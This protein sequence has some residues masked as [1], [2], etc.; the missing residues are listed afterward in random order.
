MHTLSCPDPVAAMN[1][2]QI[3]L[4]LKHLDTYVPSTSR[5][6]CLGVRVLG[7]ACIRVPTAVGTQTERCE[8]CIERIH[9]P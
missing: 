2:T 5:N 6:R 1:P 4:S 9:S 3:Q 7:I 8:F